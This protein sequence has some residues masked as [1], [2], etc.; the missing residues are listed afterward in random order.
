MTLDDHYL[1]NAARRLGERAAA[2]LNVDRMSGA[3]VSR[4][5]AARVR[6]WWAG[7]GLLRAAAVIV[8]TIGIGLYF[9]GPAPVTSQVATVPELQ[10]LSLAE[11]E[12]VLDSLVVES[13]ATYHAASSL[14]DLDEDQLTELLRSMEG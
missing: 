8:L 12:E 1:E 3:V 10:T 7:P 5:R 14:S 9:R 2:R 4:L 11:L 13:P 6:P